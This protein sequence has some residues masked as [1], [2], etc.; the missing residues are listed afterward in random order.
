MPVSQPPPAAR[1]ARAARAAPQHRRM[2][3]QVRWTNPAMRIQAVNWSG[4]RAACSLQQKNS[5]T[6]VL[7]PSA[8]LVLSPLS[9][10]DAERAQASNTTAN[11][12]VRCQP[13]QVRPYCS[14][15]TEQEQSESARVQ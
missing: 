7:K 6:Y 4:N 12:I 11:H 13:P 3:G 8:G 5:L 2:G 14:R 9:R 1:A 10:A 15:G